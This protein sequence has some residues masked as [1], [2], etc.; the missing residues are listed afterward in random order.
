MLR[1]GWKCESGESCGGT[2]KIPW[3]GGS[4]WRRGSAFRVV[5]RAQIPGVFIPRSGRWAFGVQAWALA[6][7]RAGSFSLC[8]FVDLAGSR[9][10]GSRG[11]CAR[12]CLPCPAHGLGQDD[13]PVW[14][15]DFPEPISFA[16]EGGSRWRN[17]VDLRRTS[18][19][20]HDAEEKAGAL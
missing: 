10:A 14:V 18:D 20:P 7:E 17:T 11:I 9:R 15:C 2:E 6:S 8:G 5:S 12:P 4:F 13:R 19:S 3:N 16:E 1:C